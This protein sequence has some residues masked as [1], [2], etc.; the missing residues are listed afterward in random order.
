[1]AKKKGCVLQNTPYHPQSNII[2]E[3]MVK[4]VKRDLKSMFLGQ[5]ENRSLSIETALSEQ[6]I[7]HTDRLSSLSALLRGQI[8]APLIMSFQK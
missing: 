6:I 1:M 4:T 7:P 5:I 3:G 2:M 8:R